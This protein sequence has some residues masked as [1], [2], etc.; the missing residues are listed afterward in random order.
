[1][2]QGALLPASH[3][4]TFRLHFVNEVKTG[5]PLQGGV[6]I[7]LCNSS[8][9]EKTPKLSDEFKESPW[10]TVKGLSRR[11]LYGYCKLSLHSLSRNIG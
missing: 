1:M 5:F 3:T 4:S 9:D 11:Q 7:I 10:L 6:K 8:S 2:E